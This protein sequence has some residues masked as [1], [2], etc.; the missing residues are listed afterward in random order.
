MPSGLRLVAEAAAFLRRSHAQRLVRQRVSGGTT[1][2]DPT[3]L[4]DDA[5]H[6]RR[7]DEDEH[8]DGEADQ[9]GD[10]DDDDDT[11]DDDDVDDDEDDEDEDGGDEDDQ[12]ED[13]AMEDDNGDV[14]EGAEEMMELI[15]DLRA[16][17]KSLVQKMNAR[18]NRKERD[19][20]PPDAT[21]EERA[22]AARKREVRVYKEVKALMAKREFS[23]VGVINRMILDLDAKTDRAELRKRAALQQEWFLAQRSCV[24][25]LEKELYNGENSL[26]ARLR[27]NIS[28]RAVR[29][30]RRLLTEVRNRETGQWSRMVIAQSPLTKGNGGDPH[31]TKRCN[32]ALGI[33]AKR[34][35]KAPFPLVHPD[36]MRATS[37]KL[38][39][40]RTLEVA[41]PSLDGFSGAAWDLR[42]VQSD[43]F[44]GARSAENLRE[45]PPVAA[46][47]AASVGKD[48]EFLYR[49]WIGFDG[50]KW[51][52]R[53]G[54]VRWCARTPDTKKMHNDPKFARE[55]ITY[56]GQDKNAAL[57]AASHIG[58]PISM[59]ARL[60]EGVIVTKVDVTSLPKHV[61]DDNTP[62]GIAM[63]ECLLYHCEVILPD[64]KDPEDLAK[65]VRVVQ[66]GD[67]AAGHSAFG[68]GSCIHEMGICVKCFCKKHEF[69]KAKE[70]SECIQ[71][72][73]TLQMVLAHTDPRPRMKGT[74]LPP[75]RCPCCKDLP[76]ITPEFKEQEQL[77]MANMKPS[78]LEEYIKEH[79]K[80][81]HGTELHS[82]VV[83]MQDPK[84]RSAS[85]LHR[86]MNIAQNNCVATFMAVDFCPQMRAA[87]N[88]AMDDAGMLAKFPWKNAKQRLKRLGNA[89]DA[90]ILHSNPTLLVRLHEIFYPDE[91]LDPEVVNL[92][93]QLKEAAALA[94]KVAGPSKKSKV[95]FGPKRKAAL[96]GA[97]AGADG[98]SAA[99]KLNKKPKQ[100]KQPKKGRPGVQPGV[101]PVAQQQQTAEPEDAEVLP[102]AVPNL[103]KLTDE[104]LSKLTKDELIALCREHKLTIRGSIDELRARLIELRSGDTAAAAG[105][106]DP[107]TDENLSK[108]TKVELIALCR[109]H[110]LTIRGSMDELRTRLVELRKDR[111]AADATGSG[112]TAAAAGS[113]DAEAA[114]GSG[115]VAA[116]AAP[117]NGDT[118]AAD[119][120]VEDE[121]EGQCEQLTA[122]ASD[123]RKV[124]NAKTALKVWIKAIQ[125]RNVLAAKIPGEYG[126]YDKGQLHLYAM[127]AQE[128]G[129]EWALAIQLHTGNRSNWQYVH[130]AFAHVYDDIMTHGHPDSYDDS[131]L[132]SGNKRAKTKKKNLFF[133][134]TD[135]I[136]AVYE[137]TRSTGKR[138]ANGD[139]IMKIVKRK[140]NASPAVQL[141]E[142]TWLQQQFTMR[143]ELEKQSEASKEVARMK[144]EAFA[145]ACEQTEASLSRIDALV[146]ALPGECGA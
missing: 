132:E 101:Q 42:D 65:R 5:A 32:E 100:P 60:D 10:F 85:S 129:R 19:M 78:K 99:R 38:L 71:R 43:V 3:L 110:K 134:G 26:E 87:A 31:L 4:D 8:D 97:V 119:A 72:T 1:T 111:M 94:E 16:K 67:L 70:C 108:L 33:Y 48:G 81:H 34:P 144:S 83:I 64:G 54:L 104:N 51:T 22:R 37:R 69:T 25:K 75:F 73:A 47:P 137:Q 89:N 63:R 84:W 82:E 44:D 114:A 12:D 2:C 14:P 115:D 66:G 80:S 133:G 6:A 118:V 28:V 102:E 93:K 136:G 29:R 139:L 79:L 106:G 143:R 49:L 92:I 116:A 103:D 91:M 88:E 59:R 95:I 107:L 20:L 45:R 130:H 112:D 127:K 53:N 128:A 146:S 9:Q 55:G 36:E 52:H 18:K 23:R 30:L 138:D 123:D 117:G 77:K 141:L 142:N 121:D 105:S 145:K 68:N 46:A 15:R 27:E 131:I 7:N 113:G 96:T 120:D 76:L 35:V 74:N 90:R 13:V 50:L 41:I 98:A 86:T 61:R 40:E 109:E 62:H 11:G 140:A 58:G 124:G 21:P 126:D 122:G 56:A 135:E 39:Q 57:V 17:Y 24:E 125:F